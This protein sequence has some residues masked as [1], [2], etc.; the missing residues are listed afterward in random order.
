MAVEEVLSGRNVTPAD[1]RA[2]LS[3][4]HV[5]CVARS[6]LP[7]IRTGLIVGMPESALN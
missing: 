1:D 7:R 6:Q 5:C 4:R 3:E 2:T